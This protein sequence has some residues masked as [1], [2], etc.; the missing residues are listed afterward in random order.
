MQKTPFWAAKDILLERNMPPLTF[1]K[2]AYCKS[3]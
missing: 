3:A 2:A 1:K